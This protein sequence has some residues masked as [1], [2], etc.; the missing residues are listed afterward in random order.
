MTA[1]E[2]RDYLSYGV[3]PYLGPSLLRAGS[4][5]GVPPWMANIS[6]ADYVLLE[7]RLGEFDDSIDFSWAYE[8]RPLIAPMGV[9]GGPWPAIEHFSRAWVQADSALASITSI[10]FE[11][12]NCHE[13][14]SASPAIFF[15]LIGSERHRYL[16]TARRLCGIFLV[17]PSSKVQRALD[18]CISLA[19]PGVAPTY[20]GLMLSRPQ[21]PIRIDLQLGVGSSAILGYLTKVKWPGKRE[22]V[23]A[24]LDNMTRCFPDLAPYVAFDILDGVQPRLGL[25]YILGEGQA[26]NSSQAA[27]VVRHLIGLGLCSPAKGEALLAWPGYA[28]A[29]RAGRSSFPAN[30]F[31]LSGG[32]DCFRRYL[33]HVKIVFEQH[34]VSAKAYLNC[35]HSLIR[36][37]P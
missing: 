7:F 11:A 16:E 28:L 8:P 29:H 20:L 5:H 31:V 37:Q 2:I 10:A 1:C 34:S 36:P 30:N 4:L 26:G 14:V 24:F 22:P 25:E 19:P 9:S 17:E 12:D 3:E 13:Q 35:S 15:E 33:S 21:A 6:D 27:A 18:Y 23:R 32:V